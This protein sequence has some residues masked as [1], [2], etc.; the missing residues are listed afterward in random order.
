MANDKICR[1]LKIEVHIEDR[2]PTDAAHWLGKFPW[3]LAQP[4]SKLHTQEQAVQ[5]YL[6]SRDYILESSNSEM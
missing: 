3:A 1:W 2:A 4:N 5:F 6:H